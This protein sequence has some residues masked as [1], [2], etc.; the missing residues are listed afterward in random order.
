MSKVTIGICSGGTIRVETVASLV[1]N[2]INMAQRDLAPNLLFQVGG[3]VDVNR[4]KIVE[5][6]IKGG[7]THLIFIDADMIFPEDGIFRLLEHDRDI[8]AANYNVRLDPTSQDI[9]GPTVKM[10]VDGKSVSMVKGGL[11]DKLFKCYAVATGFMLIN[12]DIF[13]KLEKPYFDAHQ[14]GGG[15]TTEDVQF[16]INANKAGIEVWCDPTLKL[17]HIGSYVY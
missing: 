8:V 6:A 17:G 10:L 2:L 5:E 14:E 16:C 4:N 7:S 1:S 3:Y 9:S 13:K 15:H 11:P 12:L